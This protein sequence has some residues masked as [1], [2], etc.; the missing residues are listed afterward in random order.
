MGIALIRTGAWSGVMNSTVFPPGL[1][2]RPGW[3]RTHGK[4]WL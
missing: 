1:S 2:R 4:P 3:H